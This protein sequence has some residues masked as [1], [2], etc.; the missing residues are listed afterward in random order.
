MSEEF[1]RYVGF[2]DDNVTG[3]CVETEIEC[4][5]ALV[6]GYKKATGSTKDIW[7]SW[8]FIKKNGYSVKKCRVIPIE[9]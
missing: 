1:I 2:R 3:P 4:I 6:Y 5:S 8:N 7:D 9:E